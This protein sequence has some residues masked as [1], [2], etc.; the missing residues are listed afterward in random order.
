M[1]TLAFSYCGSGATCQ[2]G[3][4]MDESGRKCL[5]HVFRLG[6]ES[7]MRQTA[8]IRGMPSPGL[9]GGPE[10]I[11][12]LHFFAVF[13]PTFYHGRITSVIYAIRS[14]LGKYD[15]QIVFV[16]ITYPNYAVQQH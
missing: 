9:S 14:I 12:D 16:Q 8:K 1:R 11:E 13:K 4:R 10:A 5:A 3:S 7:T 15:N 6:S 2:A